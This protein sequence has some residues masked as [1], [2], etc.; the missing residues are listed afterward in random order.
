MKQLVIMSGGKSRRLRVLGS[1]YP[2]CLVKINKKTLLEYQ[3][4][5]AKKN[6]FN[7]IIILTG[8]KYQII[9]KFL[10]KKKLF[11]NIITIKD[12]KNLGNGGALLNALEY[13]EDEFCL[14]YGDI[15][16]NINLYKLYLFF[17]KKNLIFV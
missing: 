11:N 3:I 16:T 5:L 14:I 6:K 7:N 4:Q 1:K 15:L 10:K 12:K 8:Y 17:K 13:L 9:N 2:K